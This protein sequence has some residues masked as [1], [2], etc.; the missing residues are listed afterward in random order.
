MPPVRR[1]PSRPDP[2]MRGL[3]NSRIGLSV[4]ALIVALI[5]P[6]LVGWWVERTAYGEAK[7]TESVVAP[8]RPAPPAKAPS[9]RDVRRAAIEKAG[10]DSKA[11]ALA[12]ATAPH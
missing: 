9:P 2:A 7:A 3:P 5:V 1:D 6:L 4:A 8:L 12:G 11:A 10:D